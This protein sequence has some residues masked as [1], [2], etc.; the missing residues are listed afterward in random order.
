MMLLSE[1]R[2]KQTKKVE[3][4]L[5][6]QSLSQTT[7]EDLIALLEKNKG[8]CSVRLNVT[9]PEENIRVELPSKSVKVGL[10]SQFIEDLNGFES[11]EFKVC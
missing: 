9:D 8:V 6:L 2:E 1:V 7:V 4:D 10:T 11:L 3:L 5:P